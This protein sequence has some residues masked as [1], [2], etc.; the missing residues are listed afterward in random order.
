MYKVRYVRHDINSNKSP[1]WV[2]SIHP[3]DN[4]LWQLRQ[5]RSCECNF[6]SF[7]YGKYRSKVH[8]PSQL[9]EIQ[10]FKFVLKSKS[11]TFRSHVTYKLV[12]IKYS[13]I[14]TNCTMS[15][16]A[17][18]LVL[19]VRSFSSLSNFSIA[20][21]SSSPIPTMIMDIGVNEASTRASIVVSGS[22]I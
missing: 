22:N 7:A 4:L 2:F 10:D 14:P 5:Y 13:L 17:V 8:V 1:F 3:S 15:L 6:G 12:K 20:A 11:L 9:C 21:K 16:N 19:L 18:L